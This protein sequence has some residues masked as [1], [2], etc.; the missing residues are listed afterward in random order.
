MGLKTFDALRFFDTR[1]QALQAKTKKK[2]H[3]DVDT[4]VRHHFIRFARKIMVDELNATLTLAAMGDTGGTCAG[5]FFS[6]T[7]AYMTVAY[8]VVKTF[9]DS[10]MS[11]FQFCIWLPLLYLDLLW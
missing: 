3:G 9:C 5:L 11:R 1:D 8:L 6:V 7:F 10:N 2:R 4:D